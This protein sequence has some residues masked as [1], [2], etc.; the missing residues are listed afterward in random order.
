MKTVLCYGDSNTWGC[1][2]ANEERFGLDVRWPGIL[3]TTLGTDYWVVE[4]GLSGR[5]TVWDDPIEGDKNGKTQLPSI[6]Y[7]HHPFEL[8]IIMLGTN[9]LKMRFSVPAYD[10]ANGAGVLVDIVNKS[11]CGPNGSAPQVL[12]VAPPPIATLKDFFADIFEA[13]DTKSR[14]FAHEYERVAKLYGC[15][16]LDAGSIIVSS[17][18]DGIHL[19]A[20]EHAKLAHAIADKVQQILE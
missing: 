17:E 18:Q 9:D 15:H 19:D 6:L 10:I 11:G 20:S 8:I 3:R 14:R 13:A 12:L 2:P 4:E 1:N 7:T 16:F 5:T